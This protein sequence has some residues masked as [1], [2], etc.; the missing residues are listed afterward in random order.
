MTADSSTSGPSSTKGRS[1]G[2]GHRSTGGRPS[3]PPDRRWRLNTQVTL[4]TILVAAFAVLASGLLSVSLVR[5]AAEDE[6][7]RTLGLQ[8]DLLA[9]VYGS[10]PSQALRI[11][12]TL[13]AQGISLGLVSSVGRVVTSDS[14]VE[15]AASGRE[16]ELAAGSDSS[17]VVDLGSDGVLLVETRDVSQRG[18]AV[19]LVQ[20][21]A[22]GTQAGSLVVV[23]P[24]EEA[25]AVGRDLLGPLLASLA[26]G[27]AV[28]AL[29]GWLLARRLARPLERT[30][31]AALD[32]AG[33]AREV[34][35]SPGGPLEVAEVAESLNTLSSALETSE[36]RQRQFLLSVSHE[37]R[38]PL[39]AVRGFAESVADGV[40]TGEQAEQAGGTIL[41]EAQRLDRLVSDLL[42]LARLGAQEFPLER[43]PVD[44]GDVLAGP[45]G[46][47][48]VWTKR[49][50]DVG[51]EFR[52]ELPEGAVTV[53]TDAGR[54]RQIVDGLCENALRVTP[55]GAPIVLALRADGSGDRAAAVIEVRDGGPGLTPEDCEVAFDRAV[56]Y[57]R[58][59]G[60]RRVGTGVGL[61]LV[62]GLARR[63]GGRAEVEGHG[64][65]GGAVFRVVLPRS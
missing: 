37:L 55:E 27:V 1:S 23:Q 59:R 58:Y 34:R 50:A 53:D 15:L 42:D 32:M 40:V 48:Q 14:V 46:A 19:P 18:V 4:V 31:A 38:T 57:E 47:A 30:A 54:V 61:A 17:Y 20:R 43:H 9:D 65:E 12:R 49:C 26:F 3:A 25:L 2:S 64:P 39:T 21:V 45:G 28:A 35:V 36:G 13:A 56:L 6:A 29:A 62:D 41:A 7:R 33:G 22:P 60:I 10:Q 24:R 11:A 5:S 52:T 44:L 8:A 16:A 63:L 51:V